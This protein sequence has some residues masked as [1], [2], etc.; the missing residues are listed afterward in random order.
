MQ[1]T[2]RGRQ[3]DEAVNLIGSFFHVQHFASGEFQPRKAG[4]LGIGDKFSNADLDLNLAGFGL[5]QD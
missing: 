4:V 3:P 5:R 2:S 1:T